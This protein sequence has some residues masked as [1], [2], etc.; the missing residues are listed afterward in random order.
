MAQKKRKY[1]KQP[2]ASASLQTWQNYHARC[3]EVDRYNASIVSD[4]KKKSSIISSVNKL[5][6]KR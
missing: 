5:K 6:S 3:K 2:K 4:K 1:P